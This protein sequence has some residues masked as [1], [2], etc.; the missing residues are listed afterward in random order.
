METDIL[1]N[2]VEVYSRLWSFRERG[3]TVEI[4]TPCSTTNDSFV[5]VFLTQR[6][7]EFI[8]TDGGWISEKY[9]NVL[10]DLEDDHFNRLYEYYLTQYSIST[11]E[12]KERIFYYKKTNNQLLIP[13]LVYE[14]SNFIS[15]IISSSFIQFESKKEKDSIKRFRRNADNFIASFKNKDQVKFGQSIHEKY[16]RVKFNAV[17]RNNDRL[18]L[19]NY[20]TGTTDYNFINSIGKTNM[21]FEIID[22]SGMTDFIDKKIALINNM[23]SGYKIDKIAPYLEFMGGKTQFEIVLWSEKEKI[24]ELI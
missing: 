2:I 18:S 8:I 23:A 24:K 16:S 19:I 7:N 4:I 14:V 3:D 1:K 10:I 12:A 9:Y 21:N 20:I 15:I 5:S 13:N 11:L 6:E 22:K 17:I